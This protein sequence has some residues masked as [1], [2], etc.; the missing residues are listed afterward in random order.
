MNVIWTK[1]FPSTAVSNIG[2]AA[3]L[4]HDPLA[5]YEGVVQACGS[6]QS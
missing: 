2:M 1:K 4:P 3:I 5:D 6:S